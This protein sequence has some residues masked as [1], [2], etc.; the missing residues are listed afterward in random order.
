MKHSLF[1]I[2]II[3]MNSISWG[4]TVGNKISGFVYDNK[5]FERIPEAIIYTEF[6]LLGRS[7]S[8]GYF[9]IST[10]KSVLSFSIK[11]LGYKESK[12]TMEVEEDDDNEIVIYLT[13]DPIELE[14]VTI[15]G[16]RYTEN[17][18][19]TY[20]LLNGEIKNIPVFLEADALRALHALPGVTSSSDLNSQ[21][22]LR[23]G[24]YDET[25]ISLDGIPLYNA[26]HLGGIY[27]SVNPDI[28]E[29]ERIYPSNYPIHYDDFLS[30][31]VDMQTKTGNSER[32]KGI[33]SIGLVSSKA[34]LEGPFSG[35]SFILSARRTYLDL[36]NDMFTTAYNFPYYFYELYG[37]YTLP[38]GDKHIISFSI[39]YSKDVFDNYYSRE[40]VYDNETLNWR[41]LSGKLNYT[42]LI[43]GNSNLKFNFIYSGS[44]QNSDTYT[45]GYYQKNKY[46]K[47]FLDNLFSHIVLNAEYNYKGEGWETKLGLKLNLYEMDYNWD[48]NDVHY[49]ISLDMNVEDILFDYAPK[50]YMYRELSKTLKFYSVNSI[51]FSKKLKA[52]TALGVTYFPSQEILFIKPF[53]NVNYL[54]LPAVNV[55]LSFGQYFQPVYTKRDK[56]NISFFSPFSA[57]FFGKEKSEIPQSNHYSFGVDVAN[58]PM[59][60]RFEI[61]A[62]Y[63]SRK[64]IPTAIDSEEQVKFYGGYACGLDMLLKR[65]IG[66]V[67]GWFAYSYSRSVKSNEQYSFF[68]GYDRTHTFKAL[69]NMELSNHWN[70]NTFWIIGSGL[71]YTQPGQKY[72]SIGDYNDGGY[73]PESL[74]RNIYWKITEGRQNSVRF[75]GYD[76]LDVGITGKFIWWNSVVVKPYL[77]IMNVYNSKN[78]FQF[79]AHT[80]DTS[81]EAGEERG[82]QI[83]PTIGII[84]ELL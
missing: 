32:I 45:Y 34:F 76:R 21:V 39:F 29:K 83:L 69:L 42:Y 54:L 56:V 52:V 63:K 46:D 9:R 5:S 17:Y 12:I 31:I 61:E 62:Y 36:L 20:E 60:M 74:D 82:S 15:S 58:L 64:N 14:S 24:N 47:L 67:T 84:L 75:M 33:A 2:F 41:N 3:G 26:Y 81:N 16:E 10:S 77:Q 80:W 8:T 73:F 38:L 49:Q 59:N 78:P 30:G 53:I 40:K 28:I 68:A 79:E 27:G 25:S 57:Y 1:I 44:F 4:Q 43:N 37:K 13:P 65:E 48:V 35:G 7:N 51:N 11:A 71:P 22:F 18:S 23:G 72:A 6:E 19:N 50:Q 55:K 66:D 70:I